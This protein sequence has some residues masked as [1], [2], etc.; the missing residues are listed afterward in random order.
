MV[1]PSD[2]FEGVAEL[3]EEG[4][5]Q[6]KSLQ[7]VGQPLGGLSLYV[8]VFPLIGRNITITIQ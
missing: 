2:F 3:V 7:V 6:A 8:H 4:V 1:C 5:I